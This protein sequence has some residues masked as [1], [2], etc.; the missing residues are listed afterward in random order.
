[1]KEIMSSKRRRPFL[2]S[3]WAAVVAS[4]ACAGLLVDATAGSNRGAGGQRGR[5]GQP[6]QKA[7]AGNPSRSSGNQH[8]HGSGF[9][10]VEDTPTARRRAAAGHAEQGAFPGV[11]VPPIS[12]AGSSS[13]TP[14]SDLGTAGPTSGGR[15]GRSP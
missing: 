6:G 12:P 13:T 3:C 1:M 4:C 2:L 5:A 9:P 7:A 14:G 8:H 10:L 15:R 11:P